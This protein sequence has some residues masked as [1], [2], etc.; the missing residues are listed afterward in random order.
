MILFRPIQE[1]DI[2][3]VYNLALEAHAGITSLPKNRRLIQE[4]INLAVSQTKEL[5]FFGLFDDL[6]KKLIG[7]SAIK[8]NTQKEFPFNYYKITEDVRSYSEEFRN[9]SKKTTLLVPKKA[10]YFFSELCTL[11]LTK[12]E[13]RHGLGR[14][15]SLSRFLFIKMNRSFFNDILIASLRGVFNEEGL[16]PFWECIGRKFVDLPYEAFIDILRNHPELMVSVIPSTYPTVELLPFEARQAIGA[17]HK[18]TQGARHLLEDQGLFFDNEIDLFDGGPFIKGSIDMLKPLRLSETATV[19]TIK[20]YEFMA[21][22]LIAKTSPFQ[23]VLGHCYKD[24]KGL[25]VDQAT[26]KSLSLDVGSEVI[27]LKLEGGV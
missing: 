12:K 5:Y 17:T 18:N 4:K 8:A 16:S 25:V 15:L 3:D 14:L 21:D 24:D 19:S 11:F 20:S 13:R 1:S 9:H 22:T 2:D 10:P 23:V 6:Q 27:Y 26:A 7:V